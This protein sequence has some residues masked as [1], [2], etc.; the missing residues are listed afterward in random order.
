MPAGQPPSRPVGFSA[1]EP[2]PR[3]EAA[4]ERWVP[5]R[6]VTTRPF[7]RRAVDLTEVRPPL[8]SP[9]VKCR[10]HRVA[11]VWKRPVFPASRP[12]PR[13][14]NRRPTASAPK[15]PIRPMEVAQPAAPAGYSRRLSPPAATEVATSPPESAPPEPAGTPSGSRRRKASAWLPRLC[16]P[17]GFTRTGELGTGPWRGARGFGSR[18]GTPRRG[19]T[20]V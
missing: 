14:S 1:G 2:A 16:S 20:I 13:R 7:P 10:A 15:A 17:R 12:L 11:T 8:S 19:S 3:T 18:S 4:A 5:S 9:A 6:S